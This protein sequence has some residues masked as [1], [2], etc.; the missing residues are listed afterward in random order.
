MLCGWNLDKTV[1]FSD[2]YRFIE[3]D[4]ER[5]AVCTSK[6]FYPNYMSHSV[7]FPTSQ[8]LWGCISNKGVG[9]L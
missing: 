8:L 7:K 5:Y 1:I 3:Y 4:I 2:E 6:A 9:K